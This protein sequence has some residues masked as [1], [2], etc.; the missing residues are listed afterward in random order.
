MVDAIAM[1]R[2]YA[3]SRGSRWKGEIGMRFREYNASE[4]QRLKMM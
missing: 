4:Y 1:D 2:D 3:L